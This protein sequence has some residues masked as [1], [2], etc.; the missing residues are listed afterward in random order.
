[1]TPLSFPGEGNTEQE[2]VIQEQNK[3]LAAQQQINDAQ[4]KKIAS[5]QEQL[6]E[7]RK[8]LSSQEIRSPLKLLI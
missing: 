1:M 3:Q 2:L 7:I 6:D 4:D 5:L 8:L